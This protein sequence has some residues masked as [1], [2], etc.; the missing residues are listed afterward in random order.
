MN[1]SVDFRE[2]AVLQIEA[3]M[4]TM[5]PWKKVTIGKVIEV[6]RIREET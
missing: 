3:I 5:W 4:Q 1:E 6:I 2:K